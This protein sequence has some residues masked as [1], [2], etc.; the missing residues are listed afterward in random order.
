MR[1]RSMCG[2]KEG[3]VW[4]MG[5]YEGEGYLGGE[6]IWNCTIHYASVVMQIPFFGWCSRSL[7]NFIHIEI[8][9]GKLCGS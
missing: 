1:E 6:R 3:G 8:T 4:S 9:T 2:Y 5:G 7:L